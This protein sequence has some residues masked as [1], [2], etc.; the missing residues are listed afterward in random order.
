MHRTRLVYSL[1]SHRLLMS[2]DMNN[3]LR[4]CCLCVPCITGNKAKANDLNPKYRTNLLLMLF[5]LVLL[6]SLLWRPFTI[7]CF[8]EQVLYTLACPFS[9]T[10][11]DAICKPLT[12]WACNRIALLYSCEHR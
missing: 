8:H 6:E 11:L 12:P 9:K 2:V 3:K 10:E 4:I 5:D 7:S 1:A